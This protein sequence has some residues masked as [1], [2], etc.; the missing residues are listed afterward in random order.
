MSQMSKSKPLRGQKKQFSNSEVL[1]EWQKGML[2]W[3]AA[4]EAHKLAPPDDGFAARLRALSEGASEAARVSRT[5]NAAGFEWPPARKADSEPPYE[6]RPDTGRRGPQ[7][8]W[9]RFD[10]AVLQLRVMAAGTDMLE[11][12]GAFE[13]IAATARELAQAVE[14]EDRGPARRRSR[15]RPAA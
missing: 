12:A 7:A 15:S 13:A 10:Q 14:G 2:G 5:A 4:V 1:G 3:A 9:R 6:L 8:L 11:V